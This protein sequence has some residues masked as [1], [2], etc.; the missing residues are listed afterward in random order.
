MLDDPAHQF[1]DFVPFKVAM[2]IIHFLE[3]V[4]VN[5]SQE[6]IMILAVGPA[7][8]FNY[9]DIKMTPVIEACQ[10]IGNG[11]EFELVHELYFADKPVYF[12][13]EF[14]GI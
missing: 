12:R 9:F 11:K 2:P 14:I 10:A 4:H 8:L 1:Q 6:Q 7:G 3:I 5:H 13:F